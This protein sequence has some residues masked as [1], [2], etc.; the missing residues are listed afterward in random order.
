[1]RVPE[2]PPASPEEPSPDRQV[3]ELLLEKNPFYLISAAMVIHGAGFWFKAGGGHDPWKLMGLL[4]VFLV[5]LAV[6][7]V[8]IVRFGKV[9]DD[10]RS[11]FIIL[12]MMF[13]ELALSFDST[14]VA[15]PAQG[16]PLLVFGWLFAAVTF[17]GVMA[18]LSIRLR[19][20]FRV[21]LHAM[22]VLLFLYP[23]TMVR[24]IGGSA[25]AL[26]NW[27]L[28]GF[29]FCVAV[30]VLMFLPAVRQGVAYAARSGTPWKWPWFPWALVGLMIAG[31]IVRGYA[32]CVSLDPAIL[33]SVTAARQL[34]SI[35]ASWFLVPIVLAIAVLM[36]EA[37]LVL[38]NRRL[39]SAAMAV[40]LLGVFLSMPPWFASPLQQ[41]FLLTFM[42][43]FGSPLF[44]TLLGCAGFYVVSIIRRVE[45]G[46]W[47][48]SL[49]VIG[50]VF[51]GP[52]SLE[53]DTEFRWLPLLMLTVV[54]LLLAVRRW[55]VVHLIAASVS[56]LPILHS[57]LLAATGEWC[58]AIEL[59]LLL[60]VCLATAVWKHP[61]ALG[62]AGILL[63][64]FSL[65][66][67]MPHGTPL[68]DASLQFRVSY[69]AALLALGLTLM[70]AFRLWFLLPGVA[71]AAACLLFIGG[72]LAWF[73]VREI[74]GWQG[75]VFYAAG[76]LCLCVA[77]GV[78]WL[79][80][81][82]PTKGAEAVGH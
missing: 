79:K 66:A 46:E 35:F 55:D 15:R 11:V 22:L 72:R 13:V 78:S 43:Q 76:I 68:E 69:L 19:K 44:L 48:L 26:I 37:G 12:M 38:K 81:V 8:A 34:D 20:L 28:F 33:Q 40:P 51:V 73:S 10:A 1:M 41:N 2:P 82:R 67:S 57:G 59:H 39:Q 5:L 77:V 49:V 27:Q 56:A 52:R 30:T 29:G 16:V 61:I 7:G 71:M 70:I 74:R 64:L 21:P 42:S 53:F 47:W 25:H 36:L 75:L 62:L 58:V 18:V 50:L 31:L 60:V 9:W 23:V 4:G 17:E 14:L 6:V 3:T 80:S 54:H 63:A 32:M 24:A 45:L 65:M